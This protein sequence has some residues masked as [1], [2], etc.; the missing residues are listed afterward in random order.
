MRLK[1][2]IFYNVFYQIAII[3]I[4][5][6]TAPYLSRVVG[7]EGVGIYS[8]SSSVASYFALFILLGVGNYGARTIARTR[9]DKLLCSKNF[10]GIYALQLIC[11]VI[12]I[13]AYIGFIIFTKSKYQTAFIIQIL[14]LLSVVLDI[15]WYFVGTE[16]FKITVR[17]G[18]FIKFV[19]VA[20]IFIFVKSPNDIYK[21]III[22]TSGVLLGQILLFPILLK[23]VC[24]VKIG[25]RDIFAHLIPNLILFVPILATSVF[26][27]MDKIMLEMINHDIAAVGIYEY[28]EK[29]VKLPVG[30]I[31][32]I[33]AVMLPKISNLLANNQESLSSSYFRMSMKYIGILVVAMAF[34]IAGVAPVFAIVFYGNDF[35]EC[36]GIITM[37]SIILITSSWANIIRTQ[38][39]IP[40]EKNNIYITAVISGAITNLVLNYIFIPRFGA[41]GAAIG[42]IGAEMI[43]C[44]IH[45][46][47]VWKKLELK[48]YLRYW[49]SYIL[50]G[51]VM[52]FCVRLLE[53]KMGVSILTLIVQVVLGAIIYVVLISI[54]LYLKKDEVFMK[55]K[56]KL[57][58][59]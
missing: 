40:Q 42:T 31:T 3:I 27:I 34:G 5:I 7:K 35:S 16:Q 26:T 55:Y 46:V 21:Y 18:M 28:S 54:L 24:F 39:L 44:L 8:Y 51:M 41:I 33:G 50:C 59:R 25:I 4:P 36:G 13:G 49:V 48:I 22:M 15:N 58:Q 23:Q 2:N 43:L 30:V 45:T 12:V 57:F 29:I 10:W 20:S 14:Y 17:R 11:S 37:L 53:I 9:D 38:Y 52:F 32:A 56:K 19:Q 6:L 1:I 47:G